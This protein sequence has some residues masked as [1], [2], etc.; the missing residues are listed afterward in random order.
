[1][2]LLRKN[3][4]ILFIVLLISGL[5]LLTVLSLARWRGLV[6][7]YNDNQ[8][9]LVQ[10]WYGSF[11]S[12]L[13][14]Q[15][16]IITLLGKDLLM[17]QRDD[18]R[19]VQADLDHIMK[20]DPEIFAGFA[21]VNTD[22]EVLE[23]TSNLESPDLPNL[24][25]RPETRDSFVYAMSTDKMVLGRTYFAPRLVI[26]A[27]KA[28]HDDN[29]QVLGVM[30]GA[31]KLNT[32]EGFLGRARLLG[33]F[34]RITILRTRDRYIQYA[35]DGALIEGF[36]DEPLPKQSY[37]NLTRTFARSAG[38]LE[39]AMSGDKAIGFVRD[40]GD[41]RG[42]VRGVAVYS[43]RYEFWLISEIEES[44]LVGQ[45]IHV[46][47]GYLTIMVVFQAGMFVLFRL[48]DNSQK[49]QQRILE[50]QAN[51]DPLTQLPN[52]NYLISQFAEWQHNK[53]RFSLLFIDLDNFK[54]INDTFGHSTGDQMLVNLAE[55]FRKIVKSD[56]LLVRHGGDEFVLLTKHDDVEK[57]EIEVTNS[58]Y[59]CCESVPADEM[60]FTPGASIGIARFPEHGNNLE[61]L[62]RSADIAM[63][64]AKKSRNRV[65]VFK[66][67][68]EDSQ[69]F[70]TKVEHLLRGAH[71]RGEI[72]MNYQPQLDAEGRFFGVEALV[73]WLSPELGM[74]SPNDFIPIAE[75]SGMMSELGYY[76]FDQS[77]EEIARIQQETGKAFRLS[78]NM[79]V[80]Q[81][82][83][84]DFAH[85]LL[86]KIKNSGVDPSLI[87]LEIT[88]NTLI[89][90][91]DQ[92]SST[93]NSI[94]K[95]GVHISLDD[96]G[97][98]Y[99]SLSILRSLTLD[100]IK[101][102]KSFVD[103]VVEDVTSMRM[104]KNIVAIGRN[105][106]VKILAEGVE[107]EQQFNCLVGIGCDFFQGYLFSKPI[108]AD[109]L[110]QYMQKTEFSV[111]KKH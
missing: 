61:T 95:A 67:E 8:S 96:F 59:G 10:Q 23:L 25:Q 12:I 100:E 22:G 70:R 108:N 7:H 51:H 29:G 63:Y 91:I 53:A 36:H 54:G 41:G 64:E 94:H 13:N 17:R 20:L 110:L 105:Y 65:H 28:I 43:P 103:H 77:L 32:A 48:I 27:R 87:A 83:E 101:I 50:F 24:L 92:I 57:N 45:F 49:E 58:I 78:L 6:N 44:Y 16:G 76:I 52:R 66:S 72:H 90:D 35:S 79:S 69:F 21:L 109:Q 56:D 2:A 84:S 11:L 106:E 5:V 3:I 18:G 39:A 26:P 15:E 33:K 111:D 97:T 93:L 68:M 89:E 62:L 60:Y 80:R 99:S 104:V 34:N 9:A 73:R 75:H 81:L 55:R 31:L 98:G 47:A 102:D 38:N 85:K 14:Q 82:V 88:E 46:F 19:D 4:W 86:Q 107:N 42:K 40:S 71:K 37:E 1:M 74:V 30:T